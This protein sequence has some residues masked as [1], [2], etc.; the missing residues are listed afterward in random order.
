MLPIE[1]LGLWHGVSLPQRPMKTRGTR[2]GARF[3]CLVS[4]PIAGLGADRV[5]RAA[6]ALRKAIH[7]RVE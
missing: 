2:M 6:R 4:I 1:N 5:A 3:V 7:A